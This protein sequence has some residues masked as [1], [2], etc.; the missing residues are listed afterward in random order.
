MWRRHAELGGNDVASGRCDFDEAGRKLLPLGPHPNGLVVFEAERLMVA[1]GDGRTSLQLNSPPRYFV[2][3]GN[4]RFNGE[5]LVHG[6]TTPLG[7]N[8]IADQVRRIRFE[9]P[10]RMVRPQSRGIR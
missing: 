8:L 1:V 7:L 9:S 10:T 4:Y 2:G 3:T 6:P 5:E